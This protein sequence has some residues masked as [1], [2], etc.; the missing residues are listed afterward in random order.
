MARVYLDTSFISACVST[1]EDPA[2]IVRREASLE[3]MAT[4]RP[5]HS[6]FISSVVLDELE[7]PAFVA[8]PEAIKLAADIE[9]LDITDQVSGVATVLVQENVMPGPAHAGDAVHVAASA[10]H[11][12]DYLLSWNVR[13][14]ANPNKVRHLQTICRRL[15]LIPPTIMTPETLWEDSE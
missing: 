7:D 4:Q 10:V 8:S 3:W 9:L 5:R 12:V 13:H 2:S 14:L 11:R 6:V 15:G 1:R